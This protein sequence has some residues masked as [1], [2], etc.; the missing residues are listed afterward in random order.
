MQRSHKK[1]HTGFFGESGTGKTSL[2]IRFLCNSHGCKCCAPHRRPVTFI[3]DDEGE[4]AER[5]GISPAC[6]PQEL[7]AAVYSGWIIFDPHL[8][9]PGNMEKALEFFCDFA[10]KVSDKIP[11]RKFF[12]VDEL[13]LKLTGS[14]IPFQ[15]KVLVQTGRRYGIVFLGQQLNELHNT[16]RNQLTEL[17]LFRTSDN[18][19]V[20]FAQSKFGFKPEELATLPDYK[21]ICRNKFGA[22]SRG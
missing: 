5:L 20:E 1:R 13:G 4:F 6:T 19:A 18:N 8:L 3:F 16:V 11:G 10:L 9:F 17:F 14:S 21:W 7:E 15:L 2:A 22:E 12:V